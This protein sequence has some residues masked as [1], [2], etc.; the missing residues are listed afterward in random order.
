MD[1]IELDEQL[2]LEAYEKK[3]IK[4]LSLP[5]LETFKT[6]IKYA[7]RNKVQALR[8]EIYKFF[9]SYP[10]PKITYGFLCGT[11]KEKNF[12][13]AEAIFRKLY[14]DVKDPKSSIQNPPAL[15]LRL[16]FPKK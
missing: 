6:K 16:M 9:E 3:V 8:H 4:P 12:D 13:R 10:A 7:P 14:S 2:E 1:R 15:W 11:I 5:S